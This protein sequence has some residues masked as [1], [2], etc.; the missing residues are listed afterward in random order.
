MNFDFDITVTPP[1]QQLE[2][3]PFGNDKDMN[4][5]SGTTNN[6]NNNSQFDIVSTAATNNSNQLTENNLSITINY[7]GQSK[8]MITIVYKSIEMPQV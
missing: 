4:N 8:V 3:K 6:N 7:N 5:S 2:V 1:P